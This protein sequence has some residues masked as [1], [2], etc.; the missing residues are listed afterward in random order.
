[1]RKE[2]NIKK[3]DR[4]IIIFGILAILSLLYSP[5]D[6]FLEKTFS[7]KQEVIAERIID[8]DTVEILREDNL[9]SVRLLGINTPE[10]GEIFY[11]EAKQF[12]KDNVENKTIGLEFVGEKYDKYRRIL[13]Y[14]FLGN[15]NINLKMVENGYANYYFYDGRDKYSDELE[16]AWDKCIENKVNLCEPSTNECVMCININS[17]FIVN[18]CSFSCNINGWIIKGEGREKFVF[19]S[20][21]QSNQQIKFNL[22]LSDSSGSLFLRDEK[23]KLVEWKK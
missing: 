22:D 13:A 3:I 8:G 1:M 20:T 7:S 18:T 16:E 17:G 2:V 11:D 23:G 6:S 21:I 4:L 15:E 9:T 12:L 5:I 10:R 14:V 19:N